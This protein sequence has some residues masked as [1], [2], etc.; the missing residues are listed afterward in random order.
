MGPHST[1]TTCK[2][3]CARAW[4][5]A[6]LGIVNRWHIKHI[7]IQASFELCRDSTIRVVLVFEAQSKN[8]ERYAI[9]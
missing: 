7:R 9:N 4:S 8:G 3:E 2:H 5:N 6:V 1:H